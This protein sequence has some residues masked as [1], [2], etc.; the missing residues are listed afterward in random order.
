MPA[1]RQK[2][3]QQQVLNS[4]PLQMQIR[5]Q[6]SVSS[7]PY[8]ACPTQAS[9]HLLSAYGSLCS[10]ASSKAFIIQPIVPLIWPS[11]ADSLHAMLLDD[12]HSACTQHLVPTHPHAHEVIIDTLLSCLACMMTCTTGSDNWHALVQA[13]EQ[14][15]LDR[16]V[17]WLYMT[18]CL[19]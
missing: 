3:R 9:I 19:A 2:L 13:E 12:H 14:Q 4:S 1:G 17:S 7:E 18:P 10:D 6:H 8:H 15:Q 5:G 16:V 11:T